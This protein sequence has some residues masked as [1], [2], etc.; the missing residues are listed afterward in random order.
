MN[1]PNFFER[2]I[3]TADAKS[4]EGDKAVEHEELVAEVVVEPGGAGRLYGVAKN[5]RGNADV[6][7]PTVG[8]RGARCEVRGTRC[9]V[10]GARV[11]RGTRNEEGVG[12]EAEQ[13]AVSVTDEGVDGIDETL[14]TGCTAQEDEH[15][16]DSTH[17]QM[18][19]LAQPFI[20][21]P[22][23]DVDAENGGQRGQGGVGTGEGG[24]DDA[25]D[26]EDFYQCKV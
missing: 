10:R 24:G 21:G 2:K 4:E 22:F 13:G 17:R 25:E 12:K 7:R 20:L 26:E 11:V 23:H 16:E 19:A 18:S 3:G 15:D 6:G 9:E 1:V 14:G 8:C 5:G